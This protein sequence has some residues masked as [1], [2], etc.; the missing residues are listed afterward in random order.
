[1]RSQLLLE[2]RSLSSSPTSSSS[3]DGT[4]DYAEFKEL[5]ANSGGAAYD[6]YMYVKFGTMPVKKDEAEVKNSAICNWSDPNYIKEAE[7]RLQQI[8]SLGNTVVGL[9]EEESQRVSLHHEIISKE[10][11]AVGVTAR[12]HHS[13]DGTDTL[14]DPL[15]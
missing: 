8:K 14:C 4:I 13:R 2:V 7:R 1:M 3:G 5:L 15:T 12:V 6:I 9:E 10:L 11:K